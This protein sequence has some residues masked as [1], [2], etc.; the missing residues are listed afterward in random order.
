MSSKRIHR[1]LNKQSKVFFAMAI[2]IPTIDA[3]RCSGCGRCIAACHLRLFAFETHEWK[4]TSVLHDSERCSGCG[5][6]AA[7]C[8]IDAITMGHKPVSTHLL[9]VEPACPTAV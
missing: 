7:N 1:C 3:A 5:K 9:P 8:A 2:R 4:K 6:C